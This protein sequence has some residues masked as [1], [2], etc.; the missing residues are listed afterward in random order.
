[1]RG[2]IIHAPKDLRIEPVP[3]VPPGPGEVRVAIQAGGICGSDLHYYNHGGTAAIRIREPMALGHE[4]A[5]AIAEVGPG[6]EH[7]TV[8]TRVAVNPSR[9]C[10]RCAYCQAGMQNECLDMHFVG[11]AMR[12][13]HDQGGFRQ[14]LTVEAAQAVPIAETLSLA[15][16]AMAEPLA[17]C[18]HA[19]RVAGPLIGKRVLITGAGPIGTLLVVCARLG[20]AR[21]IVATDI[22]PF[23]LS[24]ARRCGATSALNLSDDPEALAPYAAGKG[25]FDVHFEASGNEAALRGALAVVR[26]GGIIVQLGLGGD[27][28]LPINAIITKELQIRGSFRFHEEFELALDLMGRGLVDVKPL[29]THT[30]SFE[31]A[32]QAF[33][34]A[35]N[36]NIAMKVQLAF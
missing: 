10:S 25:V 34:T 15:E 14:S 16:A 18:L 17:V 19:A 13:P 8:G 23:P 24:I 3:R 36:R 29:L 33:E 26:A 28:A 21:E 4:I 12:M 27:F 20:G 2:V 1:M 30:I 11:S 35:G 7:L 31:E 9:P 6:V 22:N 32:V 5:G